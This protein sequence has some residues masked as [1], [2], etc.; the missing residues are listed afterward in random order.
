MADYIDF[1]P[2]REDKINEVLHNLDYYIELP[3][4]EFDDPDIAGLK[5]SQIKKY[6]KA[7]YKT[8]LTKMAGI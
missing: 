8:L 1:L 2:G 3:I 7:L 5:E 6:G 4:P